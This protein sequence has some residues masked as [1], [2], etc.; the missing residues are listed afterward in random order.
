MKREFEDQDGF[1]DAPN[2]QAS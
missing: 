1:Y 2:A